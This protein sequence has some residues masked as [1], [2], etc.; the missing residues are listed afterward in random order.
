MVFLTRVALL[1]SMLRSCEP[2]EAT[3]MTL[4]TVWGRLL[5]ELFAEKMLY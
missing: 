2:I 4:L 1:L 5:A 3:L